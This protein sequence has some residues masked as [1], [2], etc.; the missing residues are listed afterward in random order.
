MSGKGEG[1][2]FEKTSD[3]LLSLIKSV[4]FSYFTL[5]FF[6]SF[7]FISWR[8]I[9][10]QY[11]R[12]FCHTLTWIS[13]FSYFKQASSECLQ[14]ARHYTNLSVSFKVAFFISF[15]LLCIALRSEVFIYLF[16][17]YGGPQWATCRI[18]F[19][20]SGIEP[21]PSAG[22]VRSPNHCTTREF[23]T[24]IFLNLGYLIPSSHQL[25]GAGHVSSPILWGEGGVQAGHLADP[26]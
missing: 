23:P 3:Q 11:F 17:F 2:H 15:L 20:W 14:H 6:F 24:L 10:S 5:F 21:G 26:H 4:W 19:T 13:R 18:L 12:G 16:F 7:I 1:K 8:L 9:T 22:K 25:W